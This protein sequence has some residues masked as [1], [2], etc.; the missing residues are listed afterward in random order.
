MKYIPPSGSI[1]TSLGPFSARPSFSFHRT[2]VLPSGAI[3]HSSFFS[4]AQAMRRPS[5]AKY[6]PLERPAGCRK[7]DSSPSA[8]HLRIRSFG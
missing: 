1:Q 6:M 8:L 4:S 5:A 3:A 7:V 2:V